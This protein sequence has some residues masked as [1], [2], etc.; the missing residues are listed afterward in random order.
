MGRRPEQL[1]TGLR[2]EARGP[3][4]GHEARKKTPISLFCPGKIYQVVPLLMLI[5]LLKERATG[6]MIHSPSIW[7]FNCKLSWADVAALQTAEHC[8][9]FTA[10]IHDQYELPVSGN[11]S[12][13]PNSAFPGFFREIYYLLPERASCTL[14]PDSYHTS[15]QGYPY[16]LTMCRSLCTD[17]LFC[18]C[19]Y[20]SLFVGA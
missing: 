13:P 1:S 5:F 20:N 17:P 7:G 6:G 8:W 2:R 16:S 4:S 12:Q 9:L 10:H 19:L 3:N 11:C 14:A 18:C 15:F